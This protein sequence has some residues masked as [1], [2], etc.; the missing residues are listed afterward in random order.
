[1]DEVVTAIGQL[2]EAESEVKA[3]R[4]LTQRMILTQEEMVSTLILN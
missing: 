3:L 2:E 4:S 1:M